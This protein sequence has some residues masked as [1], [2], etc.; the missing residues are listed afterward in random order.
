MQKIFVFLFDSNCFFVTTPISV[1]RTNLQDPNANILCF[2]LKVSYIA[3]SDRY[4][5]DSF[6]V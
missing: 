5:S 6:A 4:A 1:L 2:R 3:V